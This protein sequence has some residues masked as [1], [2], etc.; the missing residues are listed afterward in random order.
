VRGLVVIALVCAVVPATGAAKPAAVNKPL[1]GVAGDTGRFQTQT[2]Q[3]TSVPS[4]FLGWGQGQTWGSP[5]AR[6]F[7]TL[8]PIPMIHIGTK[9]PRVQ[10]EAISPQGIAQG[11][12]DS[13]LSALAE[14]VAAYNSRI[15]V[16]FLAEMNNPG[17]LYS[18]RDRR[19]RSRGPSHS[20]A[21]YVRAFRRAYLILHGGTA[22]ELNAKLRAARLP[23][24]SR[25]VPVNPASRLTIIWNPVAGISLAT[26][27]YPGN[28]Y[29]D[30]VGNDMYA[31]TPGIASYAANEQLYRRYASK[32][33]A[34][35]EWGLQGIDDETFVR[36]I[37]A[38]LKARAR[39]RLAAYYEAR[40][41][42]PF[43][44]ASKPKSRAE[45]KRCVTPIGA[46]P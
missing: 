12:G 17:T 45:Y 21:Q 13:Y 31:S 10:R 23:G 7:A 8:P 28:A 2:S 18:P 9:L 41:G 42:S 20:P 46:V 6:L 4:V 37:C 26:E 43:D 38:F 19:G 24:V 29:V 33:Y 39:T 27:F 25:D 15:Y 32:P 44:L 16:R 1:L 22:D 5:F 11:R 40:P 34:L 3:R 30:M 36:R 35:P 14:A